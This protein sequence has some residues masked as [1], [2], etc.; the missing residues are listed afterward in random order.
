MQLITLTERELD[1]LEGEPA[2]VCKM[3]LLLRRRMDFQTGLVGADH[4]IS[5][6]GLRRSMQLAQVQGRSRS[7]SDVPSEKMVRDKAERLI[8][9]G[10]LERRTIDRRLVFFLPMSH[11]AQVRLKKVGQSYGRQAGQI[12]EGSESVETQG[13]AEDYP[14]EVGRT[15]NREVGHISGIRVNPFSE[16]KQQHTECPVDNSAALP[17]SEI[18]GWIKS[19][20]KRRGKIVAVS[21][22]DRQVKDW[23]SR[24]VRADELEEAYALAVADREKQGN[25]GPIHV[26][27]LDLFI[28]RVLARRKHWTQAW[29]SIVEEGRSLG[30]E[31]LPGEPNH[32][33]KRRVFAA[34]GISEEEAARWRD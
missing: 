23:V 8:R 10:L 25:P 24:N 32:V 3:Y 28:N 18:V 31:Q 7:D 27:F 12:W 5:W 4:P 6:W 2:E 30:I 26:G 19:A 33:F 11:R 22:A 13:F 21:E 29:S 17:F 34:A 1:A 9:V 14:Q 20:E 16:Y 15:E